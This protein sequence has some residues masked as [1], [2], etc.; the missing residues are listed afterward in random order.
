MPWLSLSPKKSCQVP[1]IVTYGY[2]EGLIDFADGDKISVK[3]LESGE[4]KVIK[5]LL[6]Y[7]SFTFRLL[8]V[9]IN[10]HAIDHVDNEQVDNPLIENQ[11]VD[12]QHWMLLT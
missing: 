9:Q 12:S 1:A 8:M 6:H 11:P 3:L 4:V 10:C 7:H 2:W 5:S